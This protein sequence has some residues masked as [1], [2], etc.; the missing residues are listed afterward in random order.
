MS[1][2]ATPACTLATSTAV[3]EL[4]PLEKAILSDY[5]KGFPLTPRPF[6]TLASQ[7]GCTEDEVLACLQRL[8]Q[9]G[10]ISRIG[11]V[12]NHRRAGA[13]TLAA[14]RA[15]VE[16]LQDIAE[17]INTYDEVNHNYLREHDLNLWFVVTAP[18]TDHLDAVIRNMETATGLKVWRLPMVRPYHIDLG[19]RPDFD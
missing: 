10:V 12:F 3:T 6:F 19:F 11:P 15:P 4:S 18:D 14:L 16:Q 2:L 1:N 7:L 17:L 5:Q 13:S 8:Q 9:Q